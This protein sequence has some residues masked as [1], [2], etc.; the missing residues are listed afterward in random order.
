M[1]NTH[2]D[3]IVVGSGITG[4]WAAKELTEKG[5]RV[6]MLERGSDLKHSQGYLGEHA[7]NWKLPYNGLPDRQILATDYALQDGGSGGA[8]DSSTLHYFNNDRLNPYIFDKNKPFYWVRGSRVGGRSLI[9]GRQAHRWS[10]QDFEANKQDGHG[11]DWPIRYDDLKDWYAYVEKFIGVSGQK[12]GLEHFPDGEFLPPMEMY[13]VEKTI[14]ARLAKKRPDLTMTIGRAAILTENHNGRAACHYC[15]PCPRGCS[16]GSYFSTQSSTLP[17][18]EATG[19]LTLR[20]NSVVEKLIY[21]EETNKVKAVR[22]IDAETKDSMEFTSDIVFMC[23]STIGTNQILLNSKSDAHPDGIANSSGTVGQYLMDH[24]MAVSGIGIFVDNI[25]RYFY[26]Y[27]PNGTYIPRFRNLPN[28]NDDVDFVRGYGFQ[29]FTQRLDWRQTFHQ[30]G[31]GKNLKDNLRKPGPWAHLLTGFGECLPN[32]NNQM[33]L[34]HSQPDRYGIGQVKVNF[35]WSENE[36]KAAADAK[37]QASDI[38]KAAGAV[39]VIPGE[40]D[41]LPGA[42][43]HEMG[44]ARMGH[45][46]KT[47]VLNKWNQSHDVPNLFV[48]DGAAMSSSAWINPS[49][50]YMAL[51]A[52]A[53]DYAVTQWRNGLI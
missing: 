52:R 2:F 19:R 37:A 22:V 47:S 30:K 8:L 17:A 13:S 27:R 50:T 38:L 29:S 35:E 49:L 36:I 42:A 41:A 3:A 20:P 51:T 43:I 18:A 53:C 24:H 32:K 31:F 14:K 44:G 33:T 9:W 10:P 4:G 15:G 48:T 7:P 34:D 21:D 5:M 6:L 39:A 1:N 46:P 12:E 28:S 40:A 25:D 26:G 11:V 16:T 23:A 45:D